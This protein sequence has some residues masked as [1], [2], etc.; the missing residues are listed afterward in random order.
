MNKYFEKVE[1]PL[2]LFSSGILADGKGSKCPEC[3]GSGKVS[4]RQKWDFEEKLN[5]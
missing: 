3:N 5:N 1:C 2:C 4:K